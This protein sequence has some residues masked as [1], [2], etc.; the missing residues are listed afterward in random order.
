MLKL[1]KRKEMERKLI[2]FGSAHI[3]EEH[4]SRMVPRGKNMWMSADIVFARSSHMVTVYHDQPV[5]PFSNGSQYDSWAYQNCEQCSKYKTCFLAERLSL[6][7]L[8]TGEI[9]FKTVKRIGYDGLSIDKNGMFAKLSECK[10]K[11]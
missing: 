3:K 2:T 7:Y 9:P 1:K 10:E 4:G 11:Q 8:N 5:R 6:A